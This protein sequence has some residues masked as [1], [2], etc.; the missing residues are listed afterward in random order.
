MAVVDYDSFQYYT[1]DQYMTWDDSWELI[2][3]V[4]YAMSPDNALHPIRNIK[5]Q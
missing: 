4:P 2:D 1:Y 3:G 5:R